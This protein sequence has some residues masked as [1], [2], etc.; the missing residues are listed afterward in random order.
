MICL[1]ACKRSVFKASSGGMAA[2]IKEGEKVFVRHTKDVKRN[3]IVVFNR[4]ENDSPGMGINFD[5][6]TDKKWYKFMYRIIALSGD[7][8]QI[9]NNR[10]IV[11]G[12][13]APAPPGSQLIYKVYS[14]KELE[15]LVPVEEDYLHHTGLEKIFNDTFIYKALL[16]KDKV[17]ALMR[18]KPVV[19]KVVEYIQETELSNT[20][21][22]AQNQ[23]AD[24]WTSSNYGPLR[25]PLPGETILV[26]ADNLLLY[27]NIEGIKLGKFRVT[28]PLFFLM[29]DNRFGANDS[30][31]IGFIPQSAMY[32]VVR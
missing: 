7:T 3:D 21:Y 11:N 24:H 16:T 13:P 14:T 30:R 8:L 15:E 5:G 20:S 31:F 27:Q 18:K 25:I 23:P 2:T 17:E 28:E 19:I 4:L 1:L 22:Y 26:T 9:V 32:G 12:R 6:S 10:V 29:G